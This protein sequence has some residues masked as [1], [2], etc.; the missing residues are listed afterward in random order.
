MSRTNLLTRLLILVMVATL[1]AVLVLAYIQN[2]LRTEGRAQI[3]S[4]SLR[5]AELLNA[6]MSNVVEGARQLT[7]AIS[8]FASVRSGD[9]ACK[10]DIELLRG[11]L[12]SYAEIAIIRADGQIICSTD[13]TAPKPADPAIAAHA[14]EVLGRGN[15]DVGAYMP[16]TAT[17]G[18]ILPLSLPFTMASG[19]PAVVMVG[20]S[21]DWMG[22]HLSEL[23]RPPE[24][25]IA[26]AD[27]N[28]VTI[29][30]YPEHE[31]YVG[32]LFPPAIRPLITAPKRGSVIVTSADGMER[33][34]AY[35][36]VGDGTIGMFV[37]I[38]FSLPTVLAN[39]DRTTIQGSMLIISGAL[40][41]LV[42]AL[43]FGQRFVRRPT[44]A[45]LAAARRWSSGDLSARARLRESAQSEFGSLAVAFN[46]MANALSG[47]QRQLQ[48]LNFSLEARVAE[49]TRD[50]TESRNRLEAEMAER[51]NSE[52]SLRQAQKLQAVGQLAGG[53][54][55][56]FN[57][58]LTAVVGALDLL[59][60]RMPPGQDKMLRLVDNALQAAE[61]GGKLT[62]QLL[63]FSRRQRLLPTPTDLNAAIGALSNLLGSTLGRTVRIQTDLQPGLW[64]AMVDPGQI[65]AAVINLAIN[66]RDAMPQGG[67]LTISTRNFTLDAASTS[68]APGEYIAVRVS[69]TGT[70]MPAEVLARVFEPFYTTKGPGRGSGLGLSQV[71]GLAKQSGGDVRIESELGHGTSVFLF[72]PRATM[73]PEAARDPAETR[74]APRRNAR[75][76]VV[77][78]DDD[79]RGMT[80]EMLLERGY[81]VELVA[82]GDAAI[83]HVA[84]DATIELALVDYGMPGMNGR[85]VIG[86]LVRIRPG[87]RTLLMTGLAELEDQEVVSADMIIRKPFNI[88]TLD[89]RIDRLLSRTQLRAVAGGLAKAG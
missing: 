81:S 5:Q 63:A 7:L 9:P 65:E 66:A 18:A 40:L 19:R 15:F 77:D 76:L 70:G 33:M 52:T 38:G 53:I 71:H 14:R 56:D 75:I 73:E 51:E 22:K 49:R 12:L 11:E 20:L 57:N 88:A 44:E 35:V 47:Q 55:H 21:L 82:T 37:S 72:L 42:L 2:N 80:G 86:E 6:D 23:K 31:Q 50:L 28:G 74:N 8:H 84:R 89:E 62:A 30:R 46:E 58:L 34:I 29:A 26:I 69:D 32:R 67:T 54:A 24:S 1:P 83:A 41:S 39:L 79:V 4:E 45:L 87:L 3:A 60:N 85:A 27:R 17:R 68:L 36:P 64:P 25:N 61:R 78:D 16:A 43:F 10:A 59:R 48:D 13:A